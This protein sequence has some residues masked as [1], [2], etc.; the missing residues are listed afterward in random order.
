MEILT[1]DWEYVTEYSRF[2]QGMSYA[3]GGVPTYT[4]AMTKVK[5]LVDH[6]LKE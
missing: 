4:E 2:L 1:T 5:A 6:L 3:A